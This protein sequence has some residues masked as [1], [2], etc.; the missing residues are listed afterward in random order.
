MALCY[1]IGAAGVILDKMWLAVITAIVFFLL[2]II[3][4]PKNLCKKWHITILIFILAGAASVVSHTASADFRQFLS[5]NPKG[6]NVSVTGTVTKI[7]SKSSGK[8]ITISKCLIHGKEEF[9]ARNLMIYADYNAKECHEG[10]V[11]KIYGKISAFQSPMNRGE[12]DAAGY[13][14]SM[15]IEAGVAA[16][17]VNVIKENTNR[18]LALIFGVKDR[19]MKSFAM[20]ASKKD[21]GVI[22]SMILGDKTELDDRIN[23]LYQRSGIAHILAISGLHISLIG[24]TLYKLLRRLGLKFAESAVLSSAVILCYGIMTGNAV[25]AVRAFVMFVVNVGAKVLGRKYDMLSSASLASILILA[26]MPLMLTNSGFLLSFG[27]VIGIV[28][29]Y[30]SFEK[31]F[32]QHENFIRGKG[33]VSIGEILIKCIGSPLMISLSVSLTTLP[34]LLLAFCEFPLY[35]VL[36]NLVVIPLMG[37]VMACGL[38]GGMSGIVCPYAGRFILGTA[39]YILAFFEALCGVSVNM[40]FGRIVTGLPGTDRIIL[41]YVLLAVLTVLPFAVK[42]EKAYAP[43]LA[44]I[45]SF[46]AALM[47]IN[48]VKELEVNMLYVG[49]GDGIYVRLPNGTNMLFDGGSTDKK[50]IG[51]YTLS[52]CLKAGGVAKLDYIFISHTD[53]DHYNGVI[54]LLENQKETGI[55]VKNLIMPDIRE[56]DTAYEMLVSAA[57]ENK[58]NVAAFGRGERI[59]EMEGF[60]RLECLAPQS[61]ASFSGKNSSSA[62][63]KMSYGNFDMLFTGDI[64]NDGE[65]L[66]I[67]S[68][69]LSKCEVLKVSH[70][71]SNNS[72][73]KEF[74]DHVR[75]STAL[76]SCGINN[77]YK[78]PGAKLL[79]RLD[80]AGAAAY[81]TAE[82]GEIRIRSSG[83]DYRIFTR[84]TLTVKTDH[85]IMD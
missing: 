32:P 65:R 70:H 54:Y 43:V 30:P 26:D 35:S 74:L 59:T 83:N 5:D 49:Q 69:D 79:E 73:P 25:S 37:L 28:K 13:Y 41:Y 6:I 31:I 44:L 56:K 52:P 9:T 61:G 42:H 47:F 51:K 72:T 24:M 78:H 39:H 7:R 19:M 34:V 81:V 29:V 57:L 48:P 85:D 64:E 75:P 62:V 33:S 82:C 2:W 22:M 60:F 55:R 67:D 20:T 45:T 46:M 66:L 38:L 3:C 15:N 58:V 77:R 21:A 27:A 12:F 80:D 50:E 23:S 14:A 17:E 68:G 8:Q 11:V 76:I 84:R 63:F 36:L 71:G 10:D 18:M 53:E 40:P 4:L 1:I 16:E